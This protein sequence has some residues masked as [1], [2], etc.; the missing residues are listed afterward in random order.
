MKIL[1]DD[2]YM[3]EKLSYSYIIM[4]MII[5]YNN[6]L[7]GTG[8]GRG[9]GSSPDSI[10]AGDTLTGCVSTPSSEALDQVSDLRYAKTLPKRI[11]SVITNNDNASS[12]GTKVT[13]S[14]FSTHFEE[15]VKDSDRIIILQIFYYFNFA[16]KLYILE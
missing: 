5:D 15:S 11:G 10:G 1:V 9:P 3:Y 6:I 4:D 12:N 2:R 13:L 7:S 14:Q 16:G 8:N